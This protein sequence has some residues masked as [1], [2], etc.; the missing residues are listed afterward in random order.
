MRLSRKHRA[1]FAPRKT[2]CPELLLQCNFREASGRTT[3]KVAD[4][5]LERSDDLSERTEGLDMHKQILDAALALIR[6]R[7]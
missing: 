3:E 4:S 7:R 5:H 6:T 2:S 1:R